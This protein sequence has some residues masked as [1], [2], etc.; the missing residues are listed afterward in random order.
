M[1]FF[2]LTRSGYEELI[3][4]LRQPPSPLWVNADVLAPA[5]L[6]QLRQEGHEITN[7]THTVDIHIRAAVEE[8]INTVKEHHAGQHIWVEYVPDL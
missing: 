4:Q 5:E 2:A 3:V 6:A 7:F 1:V 8:A